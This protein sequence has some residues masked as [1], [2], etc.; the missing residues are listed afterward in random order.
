MSGIPSI[1][2]VEPS[3]NERKRQFSRTLLGKGGLPDLKAIKSRL[4]E[5]REYSL[6]EHASLLEEFKDNITRYSGI[7]FRSAYD[8]EEAADYIKEVALGTQNIIVNRSSIVTNELKPSLERRGFHIAEPYYAEF[9]FFENRIRDYWDL[10]NLLRKDLVGNFEISTSLTDLCLLPRRKE[11]VKNCIAVLGV[12]AASA[13]DGSIFFLQHFSNISKSLEQ[14]RQVILIVGIDKLVKD[15]EDAAFQTRCMGIFGMESMLLNLRSRQ[16]EFDEIDSLP[17][18]LEHEGRAVHIILLDNGRSGILRSSFE[19]LLLCISCKACIKQCPIN[20]F[21]SKDDAVWSPKDY[22]FMFLLEDNRSMD[23]CLHCEACHVECPLDIDI[24]RLMW[25]AQADHAVKY[26]RTLRDRMLGNPE[27]LA[28]VGSLVAPFSN[29]AIDIDPGK[30]ILKEALGLDKNRRLPSFHRETFKRWFARRDG[31]TR[32]SGPS[33]RRLA[34]YVGCFANYYE[35]ETAKAL[36]QVLERNGFEVL[37]PAQKCCGLPMIA[38]KNMEGARRNAEYNIESLA[39]VVAKGYDIV[40]A[41][42]SCSLMIKQEYP[43][44]YDSQKARLVSE[45]LHYVDEYL[46]LLNRQGDLDTDLAEISESIFYHVPCH[47]KVQDIVGD[48]LEL[49]RLIPGLSIEKVNTACCGMAGYHG[50][51]KTHSDLS[52]EIGGKVFEDIRLEQA[53]KIVTSC[54]A[55]KLQIEAGTGAQAIHPILLLQEAYGL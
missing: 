51:K 43:N 40:T 33:N 39:A 49:M 7:Q 34:Y 12:N 15:K 13:K 3:A 45:H 31:R 28:R 30:T 50:Y 24:P 22:L 55:C 23:T 54:A 2:I 5:L 14:A 36:V 8:A 38:S 47:L 48:S 18:F 32:E 10:P 16:T 20:R 46:M 41:C 37:L 52:M 4:R 26:G 27:L 9:H 35:P 1:S 6:R 53:D 11:A 29:V 42:P 44:L 25:M 19:E 17:D 21:M